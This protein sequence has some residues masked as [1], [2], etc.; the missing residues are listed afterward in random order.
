[1]RKFS[2]RANPRSFGVAMT[3][4]LAAAVAVPASAASPR[5]VLKEAAQRIAASQ[6]ETPQVLPPEATS[7]MLQTV[8]RTGRMEV[9]VKLAKAPARDAVGQA[10]IRAEQQAFI[11]RALAA[12]PS[13]RV[14]GSVQL[15][16][17]AVFLDIDAAEVTTLRGEVGVQRITQGGVYQQTLAETVPYIGARALQ[18]LGVRGTG[19]RV[20]V[21]DSGIDYTHVAFGGPGTP[22]A[23]AAAFGAAPADVANT[24]TDGLFP[25]AKVLGGFDYVGALWTGAAGSP[26]LAPD[27]DP[28]AAPDATTPGGHGTHVADI[29][30]GVNGV[31]PDV[32]FYAVQVCGATVGACSGIALIQGMEFAVDPNQ[33]GDISDHV[34]IINMSLGA[35]YGQPFDDDLSF[36]VD[37]ATQFGVLTVASAGNSADKPYVTGSPAAAVTALSVAQTSVPSAGVDLA[38]IDAPVYPR[39]DRGAVFQT[40]STRPVAAITAPVIQDATNLNGCLPYAAGA[41]TG[42]IGLAD[43]GV[44]AISV[45]IQNMQAAGAVAGIVGLIDGSAPFS[46]AFGGGATPLIPGYIVNQADANDI[47]F[48]SV[49]TLDPARRLSLA[50]TVVTSSSRG[51]MFQDNR[52]KPEIGAPGASVSAS[53]GSGTGT[54]AFGG[55][56]GTSPMIAD[57]AA[58]LKSLNPQLNPQQLKR[59]L[60]NHADNTTAQASG[61]DVVATSLAPITRIGG[62][63]VRVD[64]AAGGIGTAYAYDRLNNG[65]LG[66]GLS[67]GALDVTRPLVRIPRRIVVE[68]LSNTD[69][70]F[71]IQNVSR[72]DDDAATG[73]VRLQAPP[74][75]MVA[76][77]SFRLVPVE[78]VVEGTKLRD[79]V[80]NAGMD[81]NNPVPLTINEHDG[82][83]S[84]TE[85]TGSS[86]GDS[87]SLPWHV[88]PR[89]SASVTSLSG[90][91]WSTTSFGGQIRLRNDGMGTAQLNGYSLI[92]TSPNLPRGPRGG[93]APQPDLRGVGVATF[94]VPGTVCASGYLWSFAVNTWERQS[95][96]IAVSHRIVMDVNRDGID[97]FWLVNRDVSLNNITDGRQVAFVIDLNTGVATAGFFV[98]HPTNSATTVLNACLDQFGLGVD[99]VGSRQLINVSVITDDFYF[100]GPGD[101]ILGMT[102]VP[103]GEQYVAVPDG[104]IRSGLGGNTLVFDFGRVPGTSPELGVMLQADGDRCSIG[105][106][107]AS[108]Q[109]SEAMMIAPAASPF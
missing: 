82:Y 84:F 37:R 61:A 23:Y 101:Q 20:A 99:A 39:P 27:P 54:A 96:P 58:L 45:K 67:F 53:S 72:Y 16:A 90:A 93:Q 3:A 102:I 57:S 13:A 63:E 51:P 25:T 32:R 7:A 71:R 88:L 40:W 14:I 15:V 17:N 76:A 5:D 109:A 6:L 11:A 97:D 43:R 83:L 19:V 91:N 87:F 28:I 103:F 4:L 79:N 48:G 95:L 66:V 33:D 52:I 56:S 2:D 8:D 55:T 41:L 38:R 24:T 62:G 9:M 64:R 85:M 107:G 46:A 18:N 60:M 105:S 35:N 1:M 74:F 92:G 70:I 42:V 81:G 59:L 21:L 78:L 49:V 26:P 50:G 69:A 12:A 77:N 104:D 29:I 47:R 73:A 75:I 80:M 30:G 36:A 89:K 94:E 68:N 31:A 108:T 100:G 86:D 98:Q 10:A 44:C 34:D 65:E 22:E 106:C